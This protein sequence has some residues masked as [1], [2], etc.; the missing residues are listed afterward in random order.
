MFKNDDYTSSSIVNGLEK[1]IIISDNQVMKKKLL[2][3]KFE[4]LSE[5][6][7]NLLGGFSA[8][9][10]ASSFDAGS[11]HNGCCQAGNC[12]AGCGTNII[13]FG[14]NDVPG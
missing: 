2:L 11:G 4:P 13:P 7:E 5:D 3:I 10:S 8:S 1:V 9:L 14:H 6:A 12:T